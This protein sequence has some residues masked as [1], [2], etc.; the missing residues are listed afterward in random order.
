MNTGTGELLDDPEK[1]RQLLETSPEDLETFAY[2]ETV[3][4]KEGFFEVVKIDVRRQRLVLKP[5]PSVARQSPTSE[6]V[7]E[8]SLRELLQRQ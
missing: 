6:E 5:K 1:L 8:R 4:V 7:S 3:Q 2:G